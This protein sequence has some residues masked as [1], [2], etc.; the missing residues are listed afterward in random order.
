MRKKPHE[1]QWLDVLDQR[2]LLAKE[3]L[4]SFQKLQRGYEGEV[5]FDAL[6]EYFFKEK[7]VSLDDITLRYKNS[8]VQIDKLLI[9]GH[10]VYLIDMKHYRGHY[11]FKNNTWYVGD[12][13][14]TNNIFEQ[15]RRAVRILQSIFNDNQIHLSVKGVLAFTNLHSVIEVKDEVDEEVLMTEEIPA[16]LLRLSNGDTTARHKVSQV[17]R[18]YTIAPYLTT[19]TFDIKNLGQLKSGIL[20]PHCH[21]AQ[22]Q[23]HRFTMNC[24][25]GYKE[26]KDIAYR[27]TICEFGTLFYNYNIKRAQLRI[28]FGKNLNERYLKFILQKYFTLKDSHHAKAGYINKGVLFEYWFD[29]EMNTL[30]QLQKRT[31]WKATKTSH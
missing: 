17:L 10:T 28:F 23:E 25:C 22:M 30:E 12:K 1:L 13:A 19:R 5:Q 16:W 11:V 3:E 4:E 29:K 21:Q 24:Q 7:Q 6:V 15:L 14:L 9:I 31:S 2:Y 27:R 26:A 8:V 18:H 20:C